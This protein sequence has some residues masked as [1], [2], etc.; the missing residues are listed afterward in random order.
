MLLV[1]SNPFRRIRTGLINKYRHLLPVPQGLDVIY[2][3]N[4]EKTI[5]SFPDLRI[6]HRE[7][8]VLPYWQPTAD[9]SA[10]HCLLFPSTHLPQYCSS[11]LIR[12]LPWQYICQHSQVLCNSTKRIL[13][14]PSTEWSG[15]F[16]R[17]WPLTS[18]RRQRGT[19]LNLTNHGTPNLYHWLF[20]PTLTLLRLMS[21]ARHAMHDVSAIYIGPAW[22]NKLPTFVEQSLEILGL[23]KLPLI[24]TAVH[25]E[26]L[27]MSFYDCTSV[28]ASPNQFRWLRQNLAPDRTTGGLRLYLGR[29]LARRRRL[30]NEHELIAAL[31][32]AG[33]LCIPDP[34]TLDFNSQCRLM[35]EADVVVAPHGAALSL[36]FCCV[37]GTKIV[38]IHSPGYLSPLYAWMAMI[39]ELGYS[40]LMSDTISNPLYPS[41]DDLLIDPDLVIDQLSRL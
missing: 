15:I 36:M 1:T 31:E 21:S 2:P 19:V 7:H 30:L 23:T 18:A 14:D 10:L 39:G 22:P 4:P 24:R 17:S 8:E 20:N 38:E 34:S 32:K 41:M 35:A 26:R 28:S 9:S 16:G 37:P 29:S 3:L 13:H 33:F 11:L 40:P 5:S 6:I 12:S 27:L 25:P